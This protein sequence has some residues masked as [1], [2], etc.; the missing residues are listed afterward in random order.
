MFVLNPVFSLQADKEKHMWA[1][2]FMV[3]N[4]LYDVVLE[5]SNTLEDR[6]DAEITPQ[7]IVFQPFRERIYGIQLPTNP[8]VVYY[9]VVITKWLIISWL[10]QNDIWHD[11]YYMVIKTLQGYL[12][13]VLLPGTILIMKQVS[14]W[15]TQKYFVHLWIHFLP[16]IMHLF[17]AVVDGPKQWGNGLSFLE[18]HWRSAK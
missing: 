1:E 15:S 3:Y 13:P 9:Y 4:V 14:L 7:A 18:T 5:C 16:F 6:E 8:C 2:C 11:E 17:S 12:L 10:S